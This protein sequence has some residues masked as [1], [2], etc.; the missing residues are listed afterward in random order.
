MTIQKEKELILN[1]IKARGSI[2][3]IE[4]EALLFPENSM[5]QQHLNTLIKTEDIVLMR[6]GRYKKRIQ[7]VSSF[8]IL[9]ALLDEARAYCNKNDMRLREFIEDAIEEKL[10]RPS[11]H[12]IKTDLGTHIQ[13]EIMPIVSNEY[14]TVKDTDI[15]IKRVKIPDEINIGHS[16]TIKEAVLHTL[17]ASGENG[18]DVDALAEEWGQIKSS[19]GSRL[20][21]LKNIGYATQSKNMY[22]LKQNDSGTRT[23]QK[24]L[25]YYFIQNGVKELKTLVSRT[26]LKIDVVAGYCE[27]LSAEGEILY[28]GM[29]TFSILPKKKLSGKN[30]LIK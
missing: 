30:L 21:E 28:M 25:V 11:T 13:Q 10:T 17:F 19:V 5:V 20:S 12:I 7:E 24:Q 22:Y 16:N 18:I 2:N 8:S 15:K 26:S 27:S 9:K 14:V 3:I 4:A 1:Y 6:N 23:I 29:D